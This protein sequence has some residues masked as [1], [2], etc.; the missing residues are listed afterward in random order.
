MEPPPSE[1]WP[2]GTMPDATAT[3]EPPL[4]P[5][6]ECAVSHGLRVGP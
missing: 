2:T 1:A 6:Q 5:P 3:A 4:E